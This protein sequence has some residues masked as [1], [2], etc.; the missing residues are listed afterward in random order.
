MALSYSSLS[1][2]INVIVRVKTIEPRGKNQLRCSKKSLTSY[3]QQVFF[4][5]K[6]QYRSLK[7]SLIVTSYQY[8]RLDFLFQILSR[9]INFFFCCQ[10]PNLTKASAEMNNS[11]DF[12]NISTFSG[13]TSYSM[14]HIFPLRKQIIL[15][16]QKI[17]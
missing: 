1:F 10:S 16:Q 14:T 9:V 17:C 8:L 12:K 13:I 6:S 7:Q 4:V 15:I 3:N 5:R 11:S 2:I